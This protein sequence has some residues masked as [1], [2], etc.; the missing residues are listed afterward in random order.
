MSYL[1]L[2]CTKVDFFWG[3]APP[4][5]RLGE[6]TELPYSPDPVDGFKWPYWVSRLTRLLMGCRLQ[7]T[8]TPVNDTMD[9]RLSTDCHCCRWRIPPSKKNYQG[10]KGQIAWKCLPKT[11][12][13]QPENAPE[14]VRRPDPLVELK[15]SHRPPSRNDGT[16]VREGAS[17]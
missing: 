3:S 10:V 15:H 2:K 6:L 4:Q 13:K 17:P 7:S 11:A 14:G 16:Y 9:Y 12:S 5:A 8:H 1:R